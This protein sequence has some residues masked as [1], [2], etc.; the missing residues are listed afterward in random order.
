[1]FLLLGEDIAR[2]TM[3]YY[4]HH[5]GD[6]IKATARLTDGQSMAYL[7]LLWMYYDSEKPLKPDTKVLAF[8]IG[9]TIEETELLLDSFF[10]L[11]ES[12]WHHTRCDQE[13][14]EYRSFLEKKSNAG[15]ASAQRR[16]NNSSTSEQQ[17]FNDRSTDV[18]LTNNHITNNQHIFIS[19]P[20]GEPEQKADK[21]LPG[22]DHKS[23]V[24]L[25]HQLLPTMRRVEVWN[26][27]RAG[28]LR[29]RWREVAVEL[30]ETKEIT[31]ADVLTWWEEFFKHVSKS[32]FLTGKIN[33]KSGRTFVADLEWIIKPSNF[34]KIVEGKYHVA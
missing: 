1:M 28:Y 4:Q 12:G 2:K 24:E 32:K 29:Q 19:P 26:D 22:C 7:R 34:A 14:A 15:K 10:W 9:A 3:H 16:K 11:A 31:H 18:Q 25:Y 21:K 5:I 20:D 33:D 27:T 8:Q 13:I 17:V 23:V 6:F 30:S